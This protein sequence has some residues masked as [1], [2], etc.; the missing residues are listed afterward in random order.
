MWHFEWFCVCQIAPISTSLFVYVAISMHNNV[1]WCWSLSLFARSKED[2]IDWFLPHIFVFGRAFFCHQQLMAGVPEIVAGG[3]PTQGELISA[4][5]AHHT[6]QIAN[7]FPRCIVQFWLSCSLFRHE[8]CICSPVWSQLS[9]VIVWFVV[10]HSLIHPWIHS[11]N[12]PF[13]HSYSHYSLILSFICSS[14]SVWWLIDS[15]IS[16]LVRLIVRLFTHNTLKCTSFWLYWWLD[17]TTDFL[18]VYSFWWHACICVYSFVFL[19]IFIA[20]SL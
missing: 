3:R 8:L 19:L 20:C 4:A 5:S 6:W 1:Y 16:S 12:H 11:R 17:S 14:S 13:I 10:L 7:N 15:S 18:C 2:I 9:L